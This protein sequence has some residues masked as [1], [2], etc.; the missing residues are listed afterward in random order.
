M[1]YSSLEGYVKEI[2]SFQSH[3]ISK[4]A[5]T[6]FRYYANGLPGLLFQQ[7]AQGMKLKV[8]DQI[9]NLSELYL[10]GQTIKPV[11]LL[12]EG[13]FRLV[14]FYLYPDA[15]KRIFNLDPGKLVDDCI[16]FDL[17]GIE[18]CDK[19]LNRLKQLKYLEEQVREIVNY[20]ESILP[21]EHSGVDLTE[22]FQQLELQ[23]ESFRFS[24]INSGIHMSQ[25]SFQRL[26]KQ[27]VGISPRMYTRINQFNKALNQ[28][29]SGDFQLL[30]QLAYDTN[31]ADQAHFTRSF[32]EFTGLTPTEFL[33]SL[34]K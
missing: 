30:T 19:L 10:Y 26:F 20:L 15:L 11:E 25:R 31:Y 9:H 28:L 22:A 1:N 21:K 23:N 14:I 5:Y 13:D 18:G 32:K 7:S 16:N 3:Q 29:E 6:P 33:N 17:L 12:V 2:F 24:S 27:Y 4:D 34:K 8:D